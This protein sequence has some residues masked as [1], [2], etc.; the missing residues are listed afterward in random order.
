MIFVSVSEEEE[1]EKDV[2]EEDVQEQGDDDVTQLHRD[3][4]GAP[5]GNENDGSLKFE[6][7]QSIKL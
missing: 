5:S 1:K 2:D 3:V 4:S 6:C 7:L